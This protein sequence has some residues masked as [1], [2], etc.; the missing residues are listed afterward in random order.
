MAEIYKI[1]KRKI[2][3]KV[4]RKGI[5]CLTLPYLGHA[6]RKPDFVEW[7]NKGAD[8]PAYLLSLIST[9]VIGMKFYFLVFID[10]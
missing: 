8:Q 9:F 10:V 5:K 4:K 7:N 3:N 2:V 6:A 1:F